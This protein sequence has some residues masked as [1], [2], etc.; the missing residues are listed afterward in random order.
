[1]TTPE[2]T[3]CCSIC[4]STDVECLHWV[5]P[6]SGGIDADND[7]EARCNAC[8]GIEKA[9]EL[10]TLAS[11]HSRISYFNPYKALELVKRYH[12][13]LCPEDQARLVKAWSFAMTGFDEVEESFDADIKNDVPG[14]VVD[15][16]THWFEFAT[17]EAERNDPNPD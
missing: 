4:G 9:S 7:D 11:Y 6:T 17:D 5:N 15:L 10:T 3:F 1:M 14:A 13:T 12:N 2:H 16:L 8:H